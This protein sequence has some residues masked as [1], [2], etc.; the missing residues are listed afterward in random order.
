MRQVSFLIDNIG[1]SSP[2]VNDIKL[3]PK[4][5]RSLPVDRE[6]LARISPVCV[7]TAELLRTGRRGRAQWNAEEV[8][9]QIRDIRNVD[10]LQ[11]NGVQGIDLEL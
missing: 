10:V 3:P 6:V 2:P 5:M 11:F 8:F 9:D 4:E 1:R 7:R